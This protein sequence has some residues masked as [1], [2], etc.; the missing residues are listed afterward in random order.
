MTAAPPS[1]HSSYPLLGSAFELGG[2]RLRNRTVMSPMS[3]CLGNDD[4][5]VSPRQVEFYRER[6]KGGVGM[7]IVEFTGVDRRLGLAETNQLS[8]DG[9]GNLPGHKVLVATPPAARSAACRPVPAM[10]TQNE[11]G[12][13]PHA[14]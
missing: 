7:V 1:T 5:S 14:P 2:L 12:G 4:G 9:P 10:S 11:T 3:S 6:A 13:R 8:L